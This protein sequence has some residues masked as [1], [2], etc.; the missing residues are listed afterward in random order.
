MSIVSIDERCIQQ[1]DRGEAAR[2]RPPVDREADQGVGAGADKHRPGA[3]VQGCCGD[4]SQGGEGDGVGSEGSR[5]VEE[6]PA[7]RADVESGGGG[8]GDGDAAWLPEGE[9]GVEAV[10]YGETGEI[11]AGKEDKTPTDAL[12]VSSHKD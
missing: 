6:E 10:F 4:E 8:G 9:R 2:S 12:P 7:V 3:G 11:C 1:P 5:G